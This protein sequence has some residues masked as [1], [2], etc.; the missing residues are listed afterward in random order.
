MGIEI[1]QGYGQIAI[2]QYPVK[3][4]MERVPPRVEMNIE[5]PKL[6]MKKRPFQL[7]IDQIQCFNEIGLKT[8][9]ALMDETVGIAKNTALEGIGRRAEEGDIFARINGPTIAQITAEAGWEPY[10]EFNVDVIPKSRPKIEFRGGG[11]DISFQP[12]RVDARL[13]SGRIDYSIKSGKVEITMAKYP[14]IEI[15]YVGQKIDTLI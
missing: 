13:E 8:Y 7:E 6:E 4:E 10:R 5:K 1:K 15:N 9:Q 12:G 2:R 11:V 3:L 14:F